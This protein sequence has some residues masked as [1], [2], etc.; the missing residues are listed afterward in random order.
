MLKVKLLHSDAKVPTRANSTD[1][2]LDL[3][4]VETDVISPS[5]WRSMPTGIAISIPEGY[6]AF[7]KPRSGLAAKGAID[8]LA[9]VI[10]SSFRGQI[11]VVIIN[12]GAMPFV[13]N[14][15]DR[16][17]QLVIQKVELW[18]PVVVEELDETERG[19]NGFGSS[20][21]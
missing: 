10:D 15:G 2:G 14:P 6:A 8:I 18:N 19:E 13:I 11:K 1:A 3:Y 21:K 5:S 12:H 17:A 16:I 9:G 7:V 4:S 20:G